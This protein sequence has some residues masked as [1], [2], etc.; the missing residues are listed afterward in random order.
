M[1]G[2]IMEQNGSDLAGAKI[3]IVDDNPTNIKVL[4]GVLEAAGYSI[5]AATSGEKALNIASRA[6]PE[7]ILLDVMMPGLD[8]YEV[9]RRLKQ[10]DV[11]RSIPVI[12]VTANDQDEGLVAGFEAGGVDYITK[13][14][15]S[16]EVLM[17]MQTHLRLSRLNQELVRKNQ[18]LEETHRRLE[19]SQSQL[20]DSLEKELQT[21]HD[22]QMGLMPKESPRLEGID[23][24]GR[25]I[26]FNH[27]GGDFF[28]YFPLTPNRLV[29]SLADVTGHAMEAAIPVVMFSGIVE[30][31]IE[32][33]GT[34]EEL[35]CR[36]NRILHK[37]LD[38]RTYV[39]FA[40]A[41]LDITS[42]FLRVGNSGCPYPYHYSARSR[43]VVELQIDAYPLGIRSETVYQTIETELAPG[44]RVVFCS[45]GIIEAANSAQELF[46]FER[47]AD[48]VREG[49]DAGQSA[50]ALLD[51]LIGSVGEFAGD[52]PQGDDIT[53]VVLHR[54]G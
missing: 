38:E 12:F 39:C 28:Q 25:C 52:V 35:F 3:L 53:C 20:I 30:S 4:L 37:T 46:G 17:R 48:A 41:E 44:D 42:G 36:L 27:V 50:S 45:D 5:L 9:C 10:D 34:L 15:R 18:E 49:C 14:F 32:I 54:E 13:P 11:T 33:E 22:M 1:N 24:A 40:M 31:Q 16:A 47:T 8:G 19:D 51:H 2:K 43:E 23:I 6:E 29:I 21:A 26:P 7:L